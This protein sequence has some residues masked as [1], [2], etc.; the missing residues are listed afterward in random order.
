MVEPTFL[1]LTRQVPDKIGLG[2]LHTMV[3]NLAEAL[4]ADGVF[5]GEFTL[6]SVTRMTILAAT[7]ESELANP[8]FALAGSAC[9]GIAVTGHPVLC[10]MNALDRFPADPLLARLRAEACIAVPLKD[11]SGRPIGAMLAAYRLPVASFRTAQSILG[12][13]APRAAAELLRKQEKDGICKS[14]ER[15]HAFVNRSEDGMWCVEF[16]RPIPTDLPPKKQLALVYRHSYYSECNDAAAK[17]LG[18]GATAEVVGRHTVDV[19]S[20]NAV[21][22]AFLELIRSA[23][24]FTT[25]ETA[26]PLPDGRRHFV[27]RKPIGHRRRW[28][29]AARLGRDARHHGL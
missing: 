25:S 19:L 4:Q 3:R 28:H 18:L 8:P 20:K 10:R 2:G 1:K 11:T 17:L 26:R 27:L 21:R 29:A 22:E 13:F 15:Y 12:V 5:V 7:P 23:Y 6:N 14:E 9:A 24:R 16:D